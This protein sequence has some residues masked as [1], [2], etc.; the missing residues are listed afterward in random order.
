M[1]VLHHTGIAAFLLHFPS[2]FLPLFVEQ[3]KFLRDFN[4]GRYMETKLANVLFS[5]ELHRRWAGEGGIKA[6]QGTHQKIEG[7]VPV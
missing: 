5:H 2:F 1:T 4:S 7:I 3:T 6:E